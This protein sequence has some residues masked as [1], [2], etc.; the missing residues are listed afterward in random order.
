MS[1]DAF[2]HFVFVDFENV[3]E[4]DLS[5]INEIPVHVTLLLGKNQKKLELELVKQ[6]KLFSAQVELVE[7]GAT[8][9][10]A[11]DLTLAYYLGR[12]V[13]RVPRANF[14]IVSKDKD[15]MPMIAHLGNQAIDVK[16][17]DR[18]EMLPFLPRRQPAP[19]AKSGAT[20]K[21][22]P[23]PKK[24]SEDRA[25][26]IIGSLKNPQSLNRPGTRK[27]LLAHLKTSLGKDATDAKVD[28]LFRQL[29]DEAVLGID[30]N[31]RVVYQIAGS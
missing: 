22:P 3:P 29:C 28:E 1:T 2:R 12:A 19:P 27:K 4:I 31:D 8:G 23:A 25:A 10:N 13:E 17:Y 11:L 26:K 9:H 16:R 21:K 20:A 24:T 30:A 6:I 15:F 18:F 7:V 5:L 14:A